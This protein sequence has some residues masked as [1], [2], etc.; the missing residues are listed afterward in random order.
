MS[1]VIVIGVA[2]GT[3]KAVGCNVLNENETSAHLHTEMGG[4]E[5]VKK[6]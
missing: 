1:D 3:G 2:G 6:R 4:R 5:T